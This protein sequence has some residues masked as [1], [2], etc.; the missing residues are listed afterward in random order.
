M[1]VYYIKLKYCVV[2]WAS[3]NKLCLYYFKLCIAVGFYNP[4]LM[5]SCGVFALSEVTH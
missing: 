5:D 2:A 4:F 1:T 3:Q